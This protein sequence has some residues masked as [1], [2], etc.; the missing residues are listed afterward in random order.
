M[1]FPHARLLL[2]TVVPDGPRADD[3]IANVA[4]LNAELVARYRRGRR[5]ELV[6]LSAAEWS[7]PRYVARAL[8]AT[9]ASGH[10]AAP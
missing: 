8:A 3:A 9:I 2:T 6:D 4:A 7:A 5:I 1:R 10:D